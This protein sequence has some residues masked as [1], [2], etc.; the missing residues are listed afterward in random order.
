[1]VGTRDLVCT[2][3]LGCWPR[4]LSSRPPPRLRTSSLHSLPLA[5]PTICTALTLQFKHIPQIRN[6]PQPCGFLIGKWTCCFCPC[7]DV[8]NLATG[9]SS[10]TSFTPVGR[11]H[12]PRTRC[13]FGTVAVKYSCIADIEVVCTPG[14]A[15][16][17]IERTC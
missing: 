9:V 3:Q 5:Q 16:M 10:T 6:S 8:T 1:M 15:A 14:L 4:S 17:S 12:M 11:L 2:C 7:V 13:P